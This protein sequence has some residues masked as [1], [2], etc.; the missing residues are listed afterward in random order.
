LRLSPSRDNQESDSAITLLGSK[1]LQFRIRSE[2]NQD[3]SVNLQEDELEATLEAIA[4]FPWAR[5]YSEILSTCTRGQ[6]LPVTWRRPL[7]AS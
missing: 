1:S 5:D 2:E 4:L 7:A 3:Y 6:R